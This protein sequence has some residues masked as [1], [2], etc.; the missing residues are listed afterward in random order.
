MNL[1]I[2]TYIINLEKRTDRRAHIEKEFSGRTEFNIHLVKAVEDSIPT[3]G[4]YK[5]LYSVI[6]EAKRQDFPFVL[7]CED[8][9]Q[10]TEHYSKEQL[11]TYIELLQGLHADVFLGGVSW[12]DRGV[13]ATEGL[14]WV[15]KF[16]GTQF[17]V[18]FS[19]FYHKILET[20]FAKNNIIDMWM[21]NLS[22]NIFVAEPTISVQYDFGYSDAT[23]I[24]NSLGRLDLLFTHTSE[25]WRALSEINSHIKRS[26]VKGLLVESDYKKMQLPTYVINLKQRRDRLNSIS[27]EFRGKSEFDV[28]IIEA[29]RE[30]NGALGLWKSIKKAVRLAKERE[31]E[32]ILICEDDH[33]FCEAY[34]KKILFSAIY[35]GAYLGADIILGGI[36]HT[37][38]IIPVNEYLC[39]VDCFQCT[40]FTVIYR[41][42]FDALLDEEFNEDDAADLKLSEMTPNKYVIHPFISEQKDFGYSDIPI[43]RLGTNQYKAMFDSCGTKISLTRQKVEQFTNDVS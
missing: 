2:P 8:D 3:V 35:Q 21:S 42:F 41:H 6:T 11:L 32:V 23:P 4:L 5:S 29:C 18:I 30:E 1:S 38:Q 12:F 9:H 16:S 37:R 36:S 33:V 10:F 27:E 43:D 17:L 40:Q 15:N 28:H 25:R 14:N 19:A 34:H 24:N 31:D 26:R 20:A 22:D 7:V 13:Q 39:W